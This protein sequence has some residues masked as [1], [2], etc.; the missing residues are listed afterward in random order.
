MAISKATYIQRQ[1][2]IRNRLEKKFVPIIQ[3]VL[4][5]YIKRVIQ[6]VKDKGVHAAQG[7]I[8]GDVV[9]DGLT[10][11]IMRLYTIAVRMATS[12][13]IVN[14]EVKALPSFIQRVLDFLDKYLLDKVVLPIS[15]TTIKIVDDL[16]TRALNNGWGV[17]QTVKELEDTELSKSR[18]RTIVRTETVRATNFAQMVQ[19]DQSPYEVE[20]MWIAIED[21]RTRLSHSHAGVD[22]ERVGLY[23][24]Y[25][26]GL[27]FPGDPRGS[28]KEVINCR[29]TQGFFAK[30]DLNGKLVPKIHRD[31]DL[32]T[33]L[34]NAA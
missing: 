25:S 26:N 13:N 8:H 11:E 22:G 24:Q 16:L 9:L 34:K 33:L 29:C 31:F 21:V 14:T 19:A 28:A 27:Y 1:K 20:K 5:S 23:E 7:Q 2:T 10:T 17:E 18:A 32:L 6:V 3:A 15:Q 12:K 30:R 4:S